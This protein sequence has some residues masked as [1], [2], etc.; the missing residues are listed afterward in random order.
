MTLITIIKTCFEKKNIHKC[1]WQHP[2]SKKW[3]CIDYVMMRQKQRRCCSDVTGVH[4]AQCWTDHILLRARLQLKLPQK[5]AKGKTKRR[6]AVASLHDE[7]VRKEY[8]KG[9]HDAVD[10]KWDK[11]ANGS[12]KRETI[13]DGLTKATESVLGRKQPDWFQVN[14]T[15]LEV[16]ISKC[17]RLFGK[18]LETH[19]QSDRKRYVA[20]RRVVVQELKRTKN[21]WFQQKAKQIELAMLQ[22]TSGRGVWQGLREIQ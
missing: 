19:Y 3:H 14:I 22:G 7:N 10:G 16:L 2:G 12:K 11:E 4:S 1:T 20:Q 18:W 6:F 5:V 15:T 13:R 17:N 9:A 21:M 8:I